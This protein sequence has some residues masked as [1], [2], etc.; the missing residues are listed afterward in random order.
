MKDELQTIRGAGH[1]TTSNTL[2]WALLLLVQCPE[3]LAKLRDEVDSIRKFEPTSQLSVAK[4]TRATVV[5]NVG[6]SRLHDAHEPFF[7]F[8]PSDAVIWMADAKRCEAGLDKAMERARSHYDRLSGE[9]KRTPPED[10]FLEGEAL[11]GL[12]DPFSVVEF[13]GGRP[14]LLV[15]AAPV[16]PK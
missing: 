11:E 8:L 1:E 2:C 3:A 6:N 4:M 15:P 12:L 16:R 10:L 5:P 14:R 13:G 9:V 7:S